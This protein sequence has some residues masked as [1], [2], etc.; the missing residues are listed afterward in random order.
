MK[1]Y[2]SDRREIH[3]A[4]FVFMRK[5]LE[6]SGSRFKMCYHCLELKISS[7]APRVWN[8]NRRQADVETISY[9][10]DI[11]T[12]ARTDSGDAKI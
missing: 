12:A 4:L 6:K 5:V 9:I 1:N 11:S 8:L 7:K 10:S 2:D 3:M